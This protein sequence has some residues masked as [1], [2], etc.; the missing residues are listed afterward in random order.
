MI[1]KLCA[2]W[3]YATPADVGNVLLH[4]A[5]TAAVYGMMH[6][7]VQRCVVYGGMRPL[8]LSEKDIPHR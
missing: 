1:F 7:L 3:W 2:R 8:R 4:T 6:C 5:W